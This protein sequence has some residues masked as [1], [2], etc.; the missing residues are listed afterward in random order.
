MIYDCFPF[1][2]EL[3]LLEIRMEELWDVVDKFVITEAITTHRGDSKN[4]YYLRNK[5]RYEKYQDKIIYLEVKNLPRSDQ[6]WIAENLQRNYFRN[7]IKYKD[8]D[9]FLISDADEIPK[10]STLQSLNLHKTTFY[11]LS[12]SMH[13]YYV[14]YMAVKPWSG[15]II[16]SGDRLRKEMPSTL[17]WSRKDQ[18]ESVDDGGWHFSFLGSPSEIRKK[19]KSYAHKEYDDD[20]IHNDK[21]IISCMEKG[22]DIFN[23][24]IEFTLNNDLPLP[25]YLTDNR[26]KFS[27]LFYKSQQ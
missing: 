12:M 17:R 27:R 8:D 20:Q 1:F 3:D 25:K 11:K 18:G 19:I 15:T 7:V 21:H 10:A 9:T 22:K 4:L 13:Y 14:N 2:N 6:A 5:K 16:I 23:R 26:D 24:G